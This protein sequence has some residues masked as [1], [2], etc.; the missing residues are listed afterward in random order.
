MMSEVC[1]FCN[2][3]KNNTAARD[4]I[5]DYIEHPLVDDFILGGTYIQILLKSGLKITLGDCDVCN[6]RKIKYTLG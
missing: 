4:T 5:L 2:N 1:E 6:C 3:D